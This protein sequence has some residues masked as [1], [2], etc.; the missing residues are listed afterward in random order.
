VSRSSRTNFEPDL[1]GSLRR[2]LDEAGDFPH[3]VLLAGCSVPQPGEGHANVY[4]IGLF[5]QR[6]V[7]NDA[8]V[9]VSNVWNEIDAM[10][11]AD[12]VGNTANRLA[13]RI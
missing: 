1:A 7:G 6:I 4:P 5:G 8:Y 11:L 9:T 10:L 2:I 12:I 13:S 3:F